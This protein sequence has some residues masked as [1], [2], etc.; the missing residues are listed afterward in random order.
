MANVPVFPPTRE[1]DLLEWSDNF[2]ALITA[3]PTIYG[4]T[5]AQASAF[6]ALN[7][8]WRSA[9]ETA[10]RPTTNSQA[11][12]IAKNQAKLEMLRGTNGA[13]ELVDIVQNF[14]GTTDAMRGDLGLRLKN[15]PTPIPAPAN[16]P[17]LAIVATLNRVVKMTLR[18]SKEQNRRG[19]PE[20]VD[21]ATIVYHVGPSAPLDPSQWVFAMNTSKT[22]VDVDLPAGVPANSQVWFTAMWFNQRKQTSPPATP[23]STV[24]GGGMAMAA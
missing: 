11:S 8:A 16:A 14:P 18:D 12:T 6:D 9:Y 19:K 20:G 13:W 10:N 24:I 1:N 4:L 3:T 17:V 7:S 2:S 21:G 23:Q 15:P 22:T 5:A